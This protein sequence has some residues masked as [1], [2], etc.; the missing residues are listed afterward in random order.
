MQDFY[1]DSAE[2]AQLVLADLYLGKCEFPSF[3]F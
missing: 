1:F 3:L 2:N